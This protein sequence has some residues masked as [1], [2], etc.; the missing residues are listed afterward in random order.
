MRDGLKLIRRPAAIACAV[1]G[2]ALLLAPA[3]APAPG[4]QADLGIT[5]SDNPDPATAGQ[6]LTYTLR[7]TNNGPAGATNVN[8]T[9]NLP[10]LIDFVSVRSSQGTCA[11]MARKVVCNLGSLSAGGAGSTATVTVLI[12]PRNAGSLSDTATVTAAQTDNQ[13][14]N[15]SATETTQVNEASPT[16]APPTHPACRD[17][18]A[19]VKGTS[20]ADQLHGTRG[21]DV[22]VA[23][24]GNDEIRSGPGVD[25]ICAGRGNDFADAGGTRDRV[26]GGPGMDRLVGRGGPDLLKGRS[27]NDVLIGNRGDDRLRGGGGRDEC[28]GGAGADSLRGCEQ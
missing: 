24:A 9:D 11:Q 27:G 6:D 26:F 16:P 4:D 5:K 17:V 12:R 28:R 19:T 20:G 25:L 2:A 13:T 14:A 18:T 1:C 23:F 10:S 3:A 8:A 7:V 21:P 22:I 15:N